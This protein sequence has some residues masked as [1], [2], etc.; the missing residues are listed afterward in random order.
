MY[1]IHLYFILFFPWLAGSIWNIHHGQHWTSG[2][3][4]IF[5]LHLHIFST[6]TSRTRKLLCKQC[7]SQQ[8]G[9]NVYWYVLR[10][11]LIWL[12]FK[13]LIH[14]EMVQISAISPEE[15]LYPGAHFTNDLFIVNQNRWKEMILVQ[16]PF[17]ISYRYRVI[18]TVCM[19]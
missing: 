5:D 16:I 3:T 8:K 9:C 10:N 19:H 11:I 17:R 2:S 13:T 6:G 18:I 14:F 4:N 12:Y 15:K 7:N 1:F